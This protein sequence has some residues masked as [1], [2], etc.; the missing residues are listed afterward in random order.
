MLLMTHNASN[1]T[2]SLIRWPGLPGTVRAERRLLP[3]GRAIAVRKT[4][5]GWAWVS[6]RLGEE[7]HGVASSRFAAMNAALFAGEV[8]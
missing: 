2:K 1:W 3:G 6:R 5:A 8:C 4:A 7:R